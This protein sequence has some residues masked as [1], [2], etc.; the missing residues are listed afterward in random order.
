MKIV[1]PIL[2]ITVSLLFITSCVTRLPFQMEV[3]RPGL[4]VTPDSGVGILLV[5]NSGVQPRNV[6]HF[7]TIEGT[8]K[9]DTAFDTSLLSGYLLESLADYLLKS[10]EY[11]QVTYLKRKDW[12][13]AK[14]N[15]EDYRN[16][17]PI[18]IVQ[19]GAFGKDSSLSFLLSLDNLQM[20]TITDVSYPRGM[21]ATRNIWLYS[22]WRVYCLKNDS[23]I[24]D[25]S[26]R[27]SLYWVKDFEN[28]I[29]AEK[30]LPAMSLSLPEIGD[31]LAEKV[32][33]RICRKWV[34]VNRG[35]FYGGS[36]RMRK[37]TE[38]LRMDS[39]DQA[40]DLWQKEYKTGFLRNR[41]R[42]AM[43]MMLFHEINGSP[44][45]A[46]QWADKAKVAMKTNAYGATYED[47]QLLEEW[48]QNLRLRVEDNKKL[49]FYL[50]RKSNQ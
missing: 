46:L 14:K 24:A 38:Y 16:A 2:L 19:R 26:C 9:R 17:A 30:L 8:A 23:L 21:V 42:A 25:F 50:E 49:K 22:Y 39:L 36:S 32:Y 43:N 12:A 7:Y 20:R 27:D 31:V 47:E 18:G 10:G 6:N 33:G 34:T 5:D 37:A 4:V 35:F 15:K 41:Y 45:A 1:F 29:P 40:S 3:L 11:D 13:F 44:E 28:G 48:K